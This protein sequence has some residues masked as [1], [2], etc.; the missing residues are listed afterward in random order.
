LLGLGKV[1]A[2]WPDFHQHCLPGIDDGSPDEQTS[3]AML[4]MSYDEGVP[5]VSA[6]PHF[7]IYQDD[8]V[9]FCE[10]RDAA[11]ERLH[12]YAIKQGGEHALPPIC[13]G[14]EVALT[15]G[16]ASTSLRGLTYSGTNNLLLELPYSRYESW[17]ADEVWNI[18]TSQDL[19]IVF[20]HLE[21]Y[22]NFMDEEALLHLVRINP[23]IVQINT[24]VFASDTKLRFL[25]SLVKENVP[26]VLGTDAHNL[27]SRP[28]TFKRVAKYLKRA[29]AASLRAYIMD[30]G[31]KGTYLDVGELSIL[32]AT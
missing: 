25:A 32:R 2:D 9:S 30:S 29:D 12:H 15:R 6:T 19:N 11:V 22:L 4:R 14:A 10:T 31:F 7:H 16:L 26:V 28:P 5:F 18:A 23:C 24:G 13:L 27:S 8:V 3:Y 17:I 20:A 1:T 21:R